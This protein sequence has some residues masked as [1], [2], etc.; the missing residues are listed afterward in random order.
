MNG[1]IVAGSQRW[2]GRLCVWNVEDVSPIDGDCRDRQQG[3]ADVHVPEEW[4]K[5]AE[6]ISVNP[7]SVEKSRSS[8]RH[9]HRREHQVGQRQR[10]D[11]EVGSVFPELFESTAALAFD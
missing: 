1:P 5:P 11:E 4:K 8:E 6:K 7:L 3:Q 9:V 2:N 10:Y